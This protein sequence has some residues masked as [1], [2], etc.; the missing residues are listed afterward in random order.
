MKKKKVIIIWLCLLSAILLIILAV[1]RGTSRTYAMP[2]SQAEQLLFAYLHL[3]KN[4]ILYKRG[5]V[6][7]Q[8]E[9]ELAIA[10]S[11]KLYRVTIQSYVPDSSLSLTCFYRY[12]LGASGGQY[13]HFEINKIDDEKTR[14][15]VDFSERYINMIFPDIYWNPGLGRENTILHAIWGGKSRRM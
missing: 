12:D 9:G 3:D 15:T 8:A 6:Q 5:N 1:G 14:V 10:M 11:K 7:A 4:R 2:Y 13:V